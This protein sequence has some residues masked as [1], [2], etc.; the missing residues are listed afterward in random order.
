M[1]GAPNRCIAMV[2]PMSKACGVTGE[3]GM[4][5]RVYVRQFVEAC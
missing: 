3:W 1:F 5:M 2:P 4:C